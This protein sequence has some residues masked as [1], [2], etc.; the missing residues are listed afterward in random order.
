MIND[1]G[2]WSIHPPLVQ[3]VFSLLHQYQSHMASIG[4]GPAEEAERDGWPITV[5]D[6]VAIIPIMGPLIRRAGPIAQFFGIAG[7]DQIRVAVQ[8]AAGDE[9]VSKILLRIDSPGGSVSG[10]EE[11]GD[12]VT[13]AAQ[14][15]P[16][17]A[18]VEGTAA[19]A[20]YWVA[21]AATEIYMGPGDLVGSIGARMAMYDYSA[22]YEE[23]GVKAL[24]IDS[25]K[26]KSA[27]MPGTEITE[28]QQVDFQRVIDFYYQGFVKAVAD[29]RNLS[30]SDVREV[31]DGR[32]FTAPEALSAGL[33]DGV[34]TFDKTLAGMKQAPKGRSTQAARAKLRI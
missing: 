14:L 29:G 3:Q 1:N 27:G 25:G 26:F 9:N 12:A 16:V 17:I 7:T 21:S 33:V 22:M 2:V 32:M 6:G 30:E 13:A 31:G 5:I 23:A 8:A 11:L 15:K 19:S 34:A 28:E 18:Q 20:A 10:I 4:A 24:P